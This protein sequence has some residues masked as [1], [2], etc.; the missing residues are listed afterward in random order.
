[1]KDDVEWLREEIW[2]FDSLNVRDER[3]EMEDE[4]ESLIQLFLREIKQS[5]RDLEQSSWLIASHV[6]TYFFGSKRT[7][8]EYESAMR[9]DEP[10]VYDILLRYKQ[11][12]AA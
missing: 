5:E 7:S 2:I 1:V 4:Y 8:K 12:F 9:I 6:E 11:T 10:L 3:S